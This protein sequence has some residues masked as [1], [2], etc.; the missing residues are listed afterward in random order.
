MEDD[1]MAVRFDEVR[2]REWE[3]IQERREKQFYDGDCARKGEAGKLDPPQNLVGLALSGGGIRSATF[4]LGLLQG[5]DKLNLVR[6]F[7]YLS[8]V[9]GGGYVGGWWSAWLARDELNPHPKRDYVFLHPEE[10]KNAGS[11]VAKLRSGKD[12]VSTGLWERLSPG[13]QRLMARYE[14]PEEAIGELKQALAA[15]LNLAIADGFFFAPLHE[16]VSVEPETS[17]ELDRHYSQL[18][19]RLKYF[20]QVNR[21]RL[22]EAYAYEFKDIFPPR[23]KIESERLR[24]ALPNAG[25]KEPEGSASAWRDPVHHLRLFASYLTP[26]KGMLSADTW[27]A[28]SVVTRNLT[29]TWLILL[30]VLIAI[31]LAGQVYFQLMFDA[32]DPRAGLDKLLEPGLLER[33]QNLVPFMDP[34]W[35]RE[36]VLGLIESARLDASNRLI[37]LTIPVAGLLGWIVLMAVLWLVCGSERFTINGLVIQVVCLGAVVTL[38]YA[39]LSIHKPLTENVAFWW[40]KPGVRIGLLIWGTGALLLTAWALK[41]P[42]V[43]ELPEDRLEGKGVWRWQAQRNRISRI[44]T[45]L[46]I[47][48]AVTSIVLL[49]SGFGHWVLVALSNIPLTENFR[50]PVAL[51]IPVVTALGGSIFTAFKSTPAGGGDEHVSRE[52]SAVARFVFA[53][54]PGLMVTVLAVSAAWLGDA[55]LG[56]IVQDIRQTNKLGLLL[57]ASIFYGVFLCFALAVYEMNWRDPRPSWSL[58]AFGC[59]AVFTVGWA[60][61]EIKIFSDGETAHTPWISLIP[62]FVATATLLIVFARIF[63]NRKWRQKLEK[64]KNYQGPPWRIAI[65]ILVLAGASNILYFSWQQGKRFDSRQQGQGSEISQQVKDQEGAQQGADPDKRNFPAPLIAV[66]ILGGGLI[67]FRLC[68]DRKGVARI[69]ELKKFL[70]ANFIG[71]RPESLWWLASLSLALPILVFGLLHTFLPTEKT[72]PKWWELVVTLM[73]ALLVI[74]LPQILIL[75]RTTASLMKQKEGAVAQE[76][77]AGRRATAAA[78]PADTG[79]VVQEAKDIDQAAAGKGPDALEKVLSKVPGLKEQSQVAFKVVACGAIGFGMVAGFTTLGGGSVAQQDVWLP[80]TIPAV[81]AFV[82]S[83]ILFELVVA[84]TPAGQNAYEHHRRLADSRLFRERRRVSLW[85]LAGFCMLIA[86]LIGYIFNVGLN[87][88]GNDSGGRSRLADIALPGLIAC[89]TIVVYEIGWGKGNN[90]R[91]LWLLASA[92]VTLAALFII[93]LIPEQNYRNII[94]GL[95]TVLGLLAAVMVWIVALGWMVDPNAVS[96]H[97]FYK[98]RLVRAYLGASNARRFSER[99]EITEAVAGDDVP[100]S[101]LKNCQRGGPYH[102]INTTLN[103]VAG[104]DLTTAQ[105]SASS[106]VLAQNYCGSSRTLYRPT[107]QYMSG[108]LTLGAAVAASGAAVSPSMGAKKPTAALAMLMT[109][110]NVRLGYWAPTPN[111]ENW[112]MSQPRLWPFYLLREFLSQTNDLSSYCYLTDGGHFDNTGLYSLVER[113]CRYIVMADCGADPQPCFQDLGDA[114]RR[115]R[116]DFGTEIE[117]DIEPFLRGKTDAP[118]QHFVVGT[119]KYSKKHARALGWRVDSRD[120]GEEE[121]RER[122]GIIIYFKPTVKGKVTA[123]VRQYAIENKQFPQQTTANQWFDEAQFESYRRLGQSC[124]ERAFGVLEATGA[125]KNKAVLCPERIKSIFVEANEHFNPENR[126]AREK[127]KTS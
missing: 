123:D 112:G 111:R 36:S 48:L 56:H 91:S 26:R 40:A 23:E 79:A 58:L 96:M 46:M 98:G 105:R 53:V 44:H 25:P 85:M 45:K 51:L 108:R 93:G 55:L 15:E 54:T 116:I 2:R 63:G 119:I 114:I 60:V 62:L 97:Q 87:H 47:A 49:F 118:R 122:T 71:R 66:A 43:R 14:E 28:V 5:M 110:L 22:D 32:F 33:L 16:R 6:I 117:L 90:R 34:A 37:Y 113:G 77:E 126:P 3:Q 78:T 18:A 13:T 100:L 102:L 64:I 39:G 80:F 104:R 61:Q 50:F 124:A 84:R 109:L 120:G 4:C 115:C 72:H 27:R 20:L 24:R 29:L 83:L 30:P 76:A 7:D 59:L 106:F 52:P 10:I 69:L 31:V 125:M 35:G 99:K 67:L 74:V 82:L 70:R 57:Q 81:I 21:Q 89:F 73:L 8:T 9:S 88:I 92:Y 75:L 12:P 94:L 11:L 19:E 107:A 68:V 127:A 38:I 86:F 95:L 42:D 103:L 1:T 17:A 41:P 101:E 65:L 121:K